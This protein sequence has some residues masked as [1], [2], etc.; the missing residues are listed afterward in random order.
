MKNN[1]SKWEKFT[2]LCLTAFMALGLINFVKTVVEANNAPQPLP[3]SQNWSNVNLIT[4]D[5]DWS[6]V[7]GIVG[8]RG[9]DIVVVTD[10]DLRTIVA[11][12]SG[13]PVD[14]NA[15]RSDPD[16]FNTGG[17][18]EFDGIPNPNIA[19][20]GSGTADFAHIVIYLN[21]TGR[22]NI[23]VAYNCSALSSAAASRLYR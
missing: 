13:T 16:V 5:D 23:Q 9:D 19:L 12:G 1:I 2:I 20:Q 15:N 7:P 3:F 4:V 21:T 11:D 10:T 17:V 22:T 6:M 14:V 18:V 8:F